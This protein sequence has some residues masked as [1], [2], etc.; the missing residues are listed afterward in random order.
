MIKNEREYRITRRQ[1]G[2][3]TDALRDLREATKRGGKDPLWLQLHEDALRSQLSD[4]ENDLREYEALRAGTVR[5]LEVN[6]LDDLPEVL[7]KARIAAGLSQEDLAARL[8]IKEQQVQRYEGT[9]YSGASLQRIQEVIKALGVTMNKNITL[10]S[11]DTVSLPQLLQKVRQ[12]GIPNDLLEK[13][14]PQ[15]SDIVQHAEARGSAPAYAALC[16]VLSRVFRWSNDQLFGNAPLSLAHPALAGVQFKLPTRQNEQR[17]AAY[18]IYAHYLAL[19]SLQCTPTLHSAPIP[20]DPAEVRAQIQEE[21][22]SLTLESIIR[23]M[24][25]LGIIVLPLRERGAFHGACWRIAGRNVVVVKQRT[26]SE[27]RWVIDTLHEFFHTGEEQGKKELTRIEEREILTVDKEELT[28]ERAATDFAVAVAL[29]GAEEMVQECVAA[30]RGKVEWLKK[31]VQQVAKR[32]GVDLAILSNYLAYRLSLQGINWWGTAASFQISTRDPWLAVRD[33]FIKR[34][35]LSGL[36]N[37]DEQI[38]LEALR[39]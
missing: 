13:L 28:N 15:Y 20:T 30:A 36:S 33:E 31:A 8:G 2:R 5:T 10:P 27:A 21:F 34:I 22:G 17:L 37:T 35:D 29:P 9:G 1:A 32:Q 26:T 14:T 16:G 38:L 3:F 4:L 39:Q 25:G 7:I 19:L 18:T 6:S 11:P 12:A 24:W 23:F